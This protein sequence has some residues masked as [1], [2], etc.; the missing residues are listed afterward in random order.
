MIPDEGTRM[1][2]VAMVIRAGGTVSSEAEV[3]RRPARLA[4]DDDSLEV[5][6]LYNCQPG[7]SELRLSSGVIHHNTLGTNTRGD[8]EYKQHTNS[9]HL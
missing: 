6:Y 3:R 5:N 2:A 8:T 1:P 7:G 4:G 9:G